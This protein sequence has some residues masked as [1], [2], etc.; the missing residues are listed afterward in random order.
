MKIKK[1][2]PI[3]ETAAE[4]IQLLRV[5]YDPNAYALLRAVMNGMHTRVKEQLEDLHSKAL[6]ISF[7]IE[8]ELQITHIDEAKIRKGY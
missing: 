8:N 7:N 3:V 6:R 1:D 4:M 2:R 5:K